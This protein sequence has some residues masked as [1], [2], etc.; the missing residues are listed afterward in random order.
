MRK[1]LSVAIALLAATAAL[2]LAV[3]T[4]VS[5]ATS[6]TTGLPYYDSLDL[7]PRWRRPSI[8]RPFEFELSTQRGT[9][10]SAADLRGRIHVA[11]FIFT[12][13]D[14]ICPAMVRQL[15]RVQ[16]AV[17]ADVRIVSYTVT[18]GLDTPDH[19][20]AFGQRHGIDSDRWLLVTGSDAHI[21]RLA[22]E[23]YFADDR[24]LRGGGDEFLHT[25]KVLLVDAK[26]DLR[27]V[28]NGTV[29]FDTDK[30]IEDIERLSSHR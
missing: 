26:G 28:Y 2:L 17:S 25:E 8:E 7:T 21:F 29:P 4:F 18:P 13:C 11:S 23:F 12:R 27:G 10:L 22:R 19:L 16:A 30:L 5:A 9:R 24:R 3:V 20:A 1:D 14:G 6:D 15:K